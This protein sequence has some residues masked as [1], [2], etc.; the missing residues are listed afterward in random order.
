MKYRYKKKLLSLSGVNPANHIGI[1]EKENFWFTKWTDFKFGNELESK[2]SQE[3][4]G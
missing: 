3:V 2:R 4:Y 1:I